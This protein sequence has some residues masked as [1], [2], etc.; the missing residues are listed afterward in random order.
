MGQEQRG[1]YLALVQVG[2]GDALGSDLAA[3]TAMN[4]QSRSED[5]YLLEKMGNGYLRKALARFGLAA[6]AT[7]GLAAK[8]S[9]DDCGD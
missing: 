2:R 3:R 5:H 8:A 7:L 4:M 1:E 9:S 6:P